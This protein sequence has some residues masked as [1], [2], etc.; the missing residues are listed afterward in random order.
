MKTPWMLLATLIATGTAYAEGEQ[1]AGLRYEK[2]IGASV[3]LTN[4]FAGA[5]EFGFAVQA[6]PLRYLELEAGAIRHKVGAEE[7]DAWLV[8][9]TARAKK[10]FKHGAVFAG[11]GMITGEHSAENGCTASGFIDF[12]GGTD[13][14]VSRHWDRALWVRGEFGGEVSLGPVAFRFSVSPV[15]QLA[16][17]DMESGCIECDDGEQGVVFT[18]GLHGRFPL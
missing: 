6:A 3:E 8:T 4:G 5:S 1:P 2:Y 16:E 10:A 14:F 18:M 12:C 7:S 17:P 11:I 9:A 13:T 15:S